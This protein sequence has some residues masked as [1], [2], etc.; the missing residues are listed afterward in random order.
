[1]KQHFPALAI[2]IASTLVVLGLATR[3]RAQV[4]TQPNEAYIVNGKTDQTKRDAII[5]LL[6]DKQAVVYKCQ[7]QELTDK[8][9]LR[10]K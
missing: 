8:V 1:M 9:T 7:K 10:K 5:A 6:S 3:C 2:A 4:K